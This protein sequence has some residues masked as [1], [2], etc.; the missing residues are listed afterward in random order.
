MTCR[1]YGSTHPPLLE[2]QTAVEAGGV[3][4]IPIRLLHRVCALITRLHPVCLWVFG[5]ANATAA[6]R[7]LANGWTA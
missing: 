3:G 6:L 5:Y 4:S 2:A 7:H 1:S